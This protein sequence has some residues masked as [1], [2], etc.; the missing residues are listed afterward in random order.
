MP[1]TDGLIF[2]IQGFSV[3][4]GPGCR[5]L[6][7]LSGCPLRCAW[8]SNPEGMLPRPRLLYRR[9]R[10]R[11]RCHR[12]DKACPHGAVRLT[13]DCTSPIALDRTLCDRCDE[14]TCV[15]ACISQALAVA[16]RRV[17]LDALLRVL[18]RDAGYWGSSGGVTFGGGEPLAQPDFL[19]AALQRCRQAYLHTAL[20]TS[21]M[22]PT[23]TLLATLPYL[24]WLL[25]DLKQ[26][27]SETH[28]RGTGA[29]NEQV[30]ANLQAVV[31]SGWSGRVLIRIPLVPGFNDDE[32]NFRA[33]AAFVRGL[34]LEE[35]QLMPFHRLG[36][37]KYEQLGLEYA[38]AE[39]ASPSPEA[40]ARHVELFTTTGLRC[41]TDEQAR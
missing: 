23:A 21:A 35:I 9:A 17:S 13:P 40:M 34:R 18:E 38:Y 28:R 14:M 1:E 37:S 12:C 16:G 32:A 36:A 8:C 20:E 30:L 19:L 10:C 2:D 24:D 31:A 3:H 33:T 25:V 6:V 11:T 29:G 4:D 39:V 5:T 22:A 7:F 41:P 15:A 26:M 27:D